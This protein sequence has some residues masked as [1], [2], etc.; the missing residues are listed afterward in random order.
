MIYTFEK[1]PRTNYGRLP[2]CIDRFT[3]LSG[4]SLV[5]RVTQISY[6]GFPDPPMRLSQSDL[7]KEEGRYVADTVAFQNMIYHQ[8]DNIISYLLWIDP[9]IYS[10][11]TVVCHSR[12]MPILRGRFFLLE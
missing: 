5:K 9:E 10:K 2:Y 3:V 7:P 6:Y 11:Y 8:L 12:S 1:T 4:S